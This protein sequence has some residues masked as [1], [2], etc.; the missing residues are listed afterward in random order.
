MT[1]RITVSRL[2]QL[3]RCRTINERQTVTLFLDG[4]TEDHTADIISHHHHHHH[5]HHHASVLVRLLNVNVGH[6]TSQSKH[7]SYCTVKAMLR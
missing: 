7:Q 6:F 1:T 3:R 2:S 4:V 5:H